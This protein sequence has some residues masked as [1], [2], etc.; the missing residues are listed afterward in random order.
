MKTY[1]YHGFNRYFGKMIY[2][3]DAP[4][5]LVCYGD[6]LTKFHVSW[7]STGT[8]CL[9]TYRRDHKLRMMF[10]LEDKVLTYQPGPRGESM[11]TKPS[12]VDCASSEVILWTPIQYQMALQVARF[13]RLSHT[14]QE[15]MEAMVRHGSVRELP[16]DLEDVRGGFHLMG[17]CAACAAGAGRREPHT[18]PPAV[19]VGVPAITP[20]VKAEPGVSPVR[21]VTEDAQEGLFSREDRVGI[22]LMFI[23]GLIF[24]IMVSKRKHVIHSHPLVYRSAECVH[25]G[26]VVILTDYM[27][28]RTSAVEL[29][30]AANDKPYETTPGES[31]HGV[32]ALES[33]SEASFVSVGIKMLAMV[34]ITHIAKPSGEHVGY[35][36]KAI[37]TIKDRVSS[38]RSDG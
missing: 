21:K 27:R 29:Y 5:T 9:Y 2:V 4:R 7:N 1:R 36:E 14:S 6:L 16:F 30:N 26:L 25:D 22:D 13:H 10:K 24:L 15:T 12:V 28:N 19:N 37:D 38:M 33:D 35:V 31:G 11:L 34:G 3:P 8:S 18:H 20:V 23:D 17:K 32:D